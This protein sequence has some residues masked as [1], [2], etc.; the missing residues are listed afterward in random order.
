MISMFSTFCWGSESNCYVNSFLECSQMQLNAFCCL[1]Y[2]N[3][4]LSILNKTE[5]MPTLILTQ[6]LF[7]TNNKLNSISLLIDGFMFNLE[8]KTFDL[9]K[10][11]IDDSQCFCINFQTHKES[12]G[13]QFSLHCDTCPVQWSL[14]FNFMV[15]LKL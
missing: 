11:V 13:S 10:H 4:W 15:Y 8:K 5:F 1:F 14:M 9:S 3:Y 7:E 2:L 6:R 12:N